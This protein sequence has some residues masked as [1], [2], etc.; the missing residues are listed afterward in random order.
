MDPKVSSAVRPARKSLE[1]SPAAWTRNLPQVYSKYWCELE[2]APKAA[3]ITTAIGFCC[4]NTSHS[5]RER[6]Q[7]WPLELFPLQLCFLLRYTERPLQSDR[8]GGKPILL[9]FHVSFAG[10]NLWL[11]CQPGVLSWDLGHSFLWLLSCKFL[12]GAV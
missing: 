7:W 12:W 10:V 9:F 6:V 4:C 5:S 8:S 2:T 1:P 3:A 11:N